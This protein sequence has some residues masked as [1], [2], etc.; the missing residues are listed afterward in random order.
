[1]LQTPTKGWPLPVRMFVTFLGDEAKVA[2]F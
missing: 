1:M 2:L